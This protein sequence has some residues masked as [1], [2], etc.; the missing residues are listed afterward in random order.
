MS[1]EERTRGR[2]ASELRLVHSGGVN[3]HHER[4]MVR[5]GEE[6]EAASVRRG[7]GRSGGPCPRSHRPA[8]PS[9]SN[10]RSR[11][12]GVIELIHR[13]PRQSAR[14]SFSYWLCASRHVFPIY[15][16]PN[17]SDEGSGACPVLGHPQKD[18][19][20]DDA[21]YKSLGDQCTSYDSTSVRIREAV[22]WSGPTV[23]AVYNAAVR[24]GAVVDHPPCPTVELKGVVVGG[25][26][27][28]RWK[29]KAG[30][31]RMWSLRTSTARTCRSEIA[32][33]PDKKNGY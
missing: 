27:E 21:I 12:D 4:V 14:S 24:T 19:T 22:T 8:P 28:R 3:G 25:A 10:D 30:S 2:S 32:R 26:M 11:A 16:L 20:A 6:G 29:E 33:S 18:T 23:D 5:H 15:L 1:A 31:H 13:R 17:T 9:P 7:E